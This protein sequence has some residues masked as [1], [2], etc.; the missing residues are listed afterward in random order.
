VIVTELGNER[1]L[2]CCRAIE[3]ASD[4]EKQSLIAALPDCFLLLDTMPCFLAQRLIDVAG[5]EF[6]SLPATPAFLL[7][8]PSEFPQT[9]A[10]IERRFLERATIPAHSYFSAGV[11]PKSDCDTVGVRLLLVSRNDLPAE[12]VQPLMKAIFESEFTNRMQPKTPAEI[13]G[14]YATH[15]AAVAYFSR[16]MPLVALQRAIDVFKQGMSIFGVFSAGALSLYGLIWK[17]KRRSSSDYLTGIRQIGESMQTLAIDGSELHV[18]REDTKQLQAKLVGLR[19]ELIE[20][21]CSG[22]VKAD[23]TFLNVLMLLND[24]RQDLNMRDREFHH[25]E[26]VPVRRRVVSQEAA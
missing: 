23:Q 13:V 19:Q 4:A 2:N 10:S 1:L 25:P 11:F 21:V 15:A 14:P 22:R 24:V 18:S 26:L 6:Q 3:E 16:D 8:P 17:K 20:D 9:Q 12:K 7:D 5:Y